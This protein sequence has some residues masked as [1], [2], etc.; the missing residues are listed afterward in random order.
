MALG[1]LAKVHK[2]RVKEAVAL[3]A[4]MTKKAEKS[5]KAGKCGEA[6]GAALGASLAAGS[7]ISDAVASKGRKKRAG[8]RIPALGG[9]MA[10]FEKNCVVISRKKAKKA[11][12]K[13]ATVKKGS[14]TFGVFSVG[15]AKKGKGRGKKK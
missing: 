5:A 15:P 7:A 12:V 6:M 1:S 14:T 13:V 11:G 3:V 4:A 9:A 8:V 2:K 10:A